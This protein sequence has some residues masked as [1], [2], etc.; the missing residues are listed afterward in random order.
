MWVRDAAI[1]GRKCVAGGNGGESPG[2]GIFLI[3]QVVLIGEMIA[4]VV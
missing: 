3:E 1:L 2:G 4:G